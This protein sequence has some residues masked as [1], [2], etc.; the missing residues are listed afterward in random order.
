MT[1]IEGD[2][3]GP[4]ISLAV[5]RVFAGADVPIDWE[6]VEV[7]PVLLNS[8]KMVL[9]K[10]VMDSMNRNKIGLKGNVLLFSAEYTVFS[11]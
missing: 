3:I 5:R 11:A 1:L 9:S 7:K 4:E 6:T 8:G 2:G 10:E